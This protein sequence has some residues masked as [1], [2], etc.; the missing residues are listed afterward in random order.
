MPTLLEAVD[1]VLERKENLF[2]GAM[3]NLVGDSEAV[4]EKLKADGPEN[5]AAKDLLSREAGDAAKLVEVYLIPSYGMNAELE[6]R[7]VLIIPTRTGLAHIA[8]EIKD[9]EV[10]VFAEGDKHVMTLVD[11]SELVLDSANCKMCVTFRVVKNDPGEP[12]THNDKADQLL[13]KLRV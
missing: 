12:M 2:I 13:L 4:G 7:Y 5:A 11:F 10:N 6:G 3:L 8:V 9:E 1:P